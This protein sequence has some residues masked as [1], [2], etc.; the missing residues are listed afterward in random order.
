MSYADTLWGE[1]I[2]ATL[3]EGAVDSL[4]ASGVDKETAEKYGPWLAMIPEFLPFVGAGVGIDNTARAVN[5]GRYM[6][7]AKEAG[8][9]LLGEA[10][11][12]VGDIAVKKIRNSDSLWNITGKE[13]AE[14]AQIPEIRRSTE[15][16]RL[17]GKRGATGNYTNLSPA[18]EESM[19]KTSPGKTREAIARENGYET[20]IED[21]FDLSLLPTMTAEDLSN[22]AIIPLRGDPTLAGTMTQ[23]SGLPFT[24]AL[25]LQSGPMYMLRSAMERGD[26]A[27]WESTLKV[28][29][30]F[31][32][33]VQQVAKDAGTDNI[34]GAYDMMGMSSSNFS[35][36]P[37]EA[38]MREMDVVRQ[39]G[40]KYPDSMVKGI[41]E[42]VRT[43][44]K[45]KF[46]DFP[47]INHPDAEAYL[48]RPGYQD[49]RKVIT[50][51]MDKAD[52]RDA[53]FPNVQQVYRD[54][55]V[56]DL[57]DVQMGTNGQV[58]VR[59]DPNAEID[60]LSTHRSYGHRIPIAEGD[61]V[62]ARL[63]RPIEHEELYVDP[64]RGYEG[65][66]T[67]GKGPPRPMN[68]T[69]KMN[70][71]AWNSPGGD[72]GK[73]YQKVEERLIKSLLDMG[74]LLD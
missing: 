44:K 46:E 30:P 66:M 35:T 17:K 13:A 56:P 52:M 54:V 11:P 55:A 63:G 74:F 60:D 1:G 69:E 10:L 49:A 15:N 8:L 48:S 37:V 67:E 38:I 68:R 45:G 28:A 22:A 32:S 9:T 50:D 72:K 39:A 59:L 14:Q 7:A 4:L 51:R 33:K 47:G 31:Q 21:T 40:G 2:A 18:R 23:M 65:I 61:G 19:L 5:D 20:V 70:T 24:D 64:H 58:L 57:H 3:E 16:E 41:D 71:T 53:G 29:K 42:A 73:G 43:T 36:M 6:D 34:W 12:I 25:D 62:V 27:A 26:P